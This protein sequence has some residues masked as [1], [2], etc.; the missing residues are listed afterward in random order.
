MI[1]HFRYV[2]LIKCKICINLKLI[3]II[4]KKYHLE[5]LILVKFG[6]KVLNFII[7]L[8]NEE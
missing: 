1:Y 5:N 4:E 3:F 2:F 8:V 7:M 6:I